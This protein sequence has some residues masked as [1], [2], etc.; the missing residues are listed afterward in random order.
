MPGFGA[1]FDRSRVGYTVGGGVEYAFMN[2]FS[3]RAEYRYSDYGAF[4]DALGAGA[5]VVHRETDN[6]VEAGM[7]YRFNS[8]VPAPVVAKY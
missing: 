4:T 2:N 1:T 5:T 7:S 3:V 6:R 8:I